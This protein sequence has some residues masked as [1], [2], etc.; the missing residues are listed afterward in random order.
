[1]SVEKIVNFYKEN[2]KKFVTVTKKDGYVS[3]GILK[4][5]TDDGYLYIKGK[6][7][8]SIFHYS[9]IVDCSARPDNR[10]EQDGP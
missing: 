2:L 10:G 1:M 8:N 6:F 7:K 3:A 4:D 9:E 5:V